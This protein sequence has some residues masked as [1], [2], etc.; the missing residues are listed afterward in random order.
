M[1]HVIN[2]QNLSFEYHAEEQT[3][4]LVLKDI[5]LQFEKGQF[6]GIIGHNGSGKSTLA[7]H[8]N[9]L[10]L[11]TEGKVYVKGMDTKD[12]NHL[13]DIRQAAGLVFQNPDNQIVAA[14]VE[15]D[16]AFGPENL[17][18]PPDEIRERVE[19]ALKAVGMWEYKDYPPHMLSGGQ[20]QR[21]A[22]AGIIAMKPECIILDEPTA[23]LDPIG[24][25]EV[26]ST[27][28]KLNK[29]DGIT[30]ILIT[31]FM[32]EVVDADRVIVMDDGKVV[33]D[34]TPKEVFKEVT[35]LKKI[36][37]SVPQ[38]TELAHQLK[39]EGFD[40]PLDILTV[41]EMVEFLCR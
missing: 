37:L 2:T 20:K 4:H 39:R 26:I 35:L 15:E 17:G 38:V 7:K 8:F 16:V 32:E 23:M 30:V 19:Y 24:R 33:L 28:K 21:V 1:E 11:P 29:E 9:A 34:G 14:I 18:I 13:W 6:I 40:V 5:N 3:R 31:H 10:L 41:E 36:G 27:I 12:T 22:I 25:R